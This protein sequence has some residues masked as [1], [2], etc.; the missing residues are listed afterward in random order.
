MPPGSA[1]TKPIFYSEILQARNTKL[2]SLGRRSTEKIPL[3]TVTFQASKPHSV[4]TD[5]AHHSPQLMLSCQ[6]RSQQRLVH[7]LP[8]YFVMI[9][10]C[11]GNCPHW[12]SCCL[13]GRGTLNLNPKIAAI[14]DKGEPEKAC[15]FIYIVSRFEIR[16]T[17][18]SDR[19][20]DSIQI[21]RTS[22]VIVSA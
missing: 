22:R 19:D 5:P 4:H 2:F 15:R 7:H 14:M 17:S 6:Q 21:A 9:Q 16:F 12:M 3:G 8:L 11:P 1:G 13:M 20:V 18:D 10:W